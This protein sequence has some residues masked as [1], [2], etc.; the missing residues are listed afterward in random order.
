MITWQQ[1]KICLR[2]SWFLLLSELSYSFAMIPRDWRHL[3]KWRK[4]DLSHREREISVHNVIN[5]NFLRLYLGASIL[6]Y[7]APGL[8]E[9]WPKYN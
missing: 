9:Y 3:E 2:E 1:R 8:I 6:Q 5:M 7:K 4:G